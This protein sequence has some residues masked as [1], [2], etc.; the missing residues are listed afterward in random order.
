MKQSKTV[1]IRPARVTDARAIKRLMDPFVEKEDLLPRSLAEIYTRVRDFRVADAGENG[2]VGCVALQV[3][4][5]DLAEVRSLAV[6]P[7]HQ[8]GGTGRRLVV[9]AL[10]EARRLGL[11]RIFALS[12]VP[13]FFKK[14]GFVEV[15]MDSLP[16]KVF[17][18]CVDCPKVNDCDEVALI[19][20]YS[21][22]LP[23]GCATL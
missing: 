22:P 13:A 12:S 23:E 2:I 7:D 8:S 21:R 10:Q 9:A 16:Q 19:F 3:V 18:D 11:P 14:L 6:H 1:Q 17:F 20:D 5:E 15:P 4:W